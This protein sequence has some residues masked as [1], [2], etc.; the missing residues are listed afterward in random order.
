MNQNA[1]ASHL[2]TVEN[3]GQL[4]EAQAQAKSQQQCSTEKVITKRDIPWRYLYRH[5]DFPEDARPAS[6]MLRTLERVHLRPV[7]ELVEPAIR[8]QCYFLREEKPKRIINWI[9][10][11][12]EG[13]YEDMPRWNEVEADAKCGCARDQDGVREAAKDGLQPRCAQKVVAQKMPGCWPA[14]E[15]A[16]SEAGGMKIEEWSTVNTSDS[17][18][19]DFE[20][21]DDISER[22]L[23]R[24]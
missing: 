2:L 11:P 1:T 21:S 14:A 23:Y 7:E 15:G 17:D 19:M 16:E 3:L 12:S 9:S 20:W 5:A 18:D 22:L 13:E 10:Y 8:Y 24:C 6:T 4:N